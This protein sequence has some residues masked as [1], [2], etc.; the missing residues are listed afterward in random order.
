[1]TFRLLAVSTLLLIMTL[2]N[3]RAQDLPTGFI[4]DESL[5]PEYELPDLFLTDSGHRVT[6]PAEW[7]AQR[8]PE[9]ARLFEREV[10]GHLPREHASV[11]FSPPPEAAVLEGRA[12]LR[13]V[14]LT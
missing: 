12:T 7:E 10:Y 5:V 11:T 1:M 9:S 14:D 3:A 13:R 2:T 8:R 6:T 4:H